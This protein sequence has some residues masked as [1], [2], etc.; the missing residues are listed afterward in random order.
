MYPQH[1]LCLRFS[2]Q[3]AF[4][5]WKRHL[6]RRRSAIVTSNLETTAKILDH[7]IPILAF[8]VWERRIF[9]LEGKTRAALGFA[10]GD[11]LAKLK[12][13]M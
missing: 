8:R 11:R 5:L 12:R 7:G 6:A 10:A 2:G 4:R 9:T 1:L 3:E 13:R